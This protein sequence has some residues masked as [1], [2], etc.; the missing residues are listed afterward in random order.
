MK[1]ILSTAAVIALVFLTACG[2]ASSVTLEDYIAE[3]DDVM[4][5]LEASA[6][7]SDVECEVSG[8]TVTFTYTLDVK[9]DDN[10]LKE[11]AETLD[12]SL[13]KTLEDEIP[14]YVKDVEGDTGVTGI[15]MKV[16][17]ADSK[18]KEIYV[19]TFD[20]KGIVKEE[21]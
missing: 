11:Y 8:N 21:Q 13:G 7:G 6:E 19:R 17:Y 15:K 14:G 12:T 10:T 20:R 1:K 2:G 18:G 5:A 3:N 4:A 16:V 9:L